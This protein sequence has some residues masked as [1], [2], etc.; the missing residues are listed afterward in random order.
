MFI[1]T[2]ISNPGIAICYILAI[3]VSLVLHEMAHGGVAY[4]M[5]DR[6]AK[7]QGRLSLN[8][9][10]HI[11]PIGFLS[12]MLVG[13]GWAKPVQIDPRNFKNYKDGMMFTALAGP[14]TNFLLGTL[15]ILILKFIP[16]STSWFGLF[17]TIF[18]QVNFMLAAFNILPIPPL[19]GYKVVIRILPDKLYVKALMVEN[20]V[21]FFLILGLVI[22]GLL[23]FIWVPV[24]NFLMMIAGIITFSPGI[25][26]LFRLF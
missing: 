17:F 1:Q 19:D 10:K 6:T 21:G 14:T 26:N 9:L 11:D 12:M 4:L 20:K 15:G 25:E 3:L 8:P 24:Y 13:F 7:S 23:R 16:I 5:G 2:L 22:T 18:V